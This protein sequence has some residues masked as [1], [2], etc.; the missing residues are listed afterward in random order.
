MSLCSCYYVPTM[1]LWCD[2]HTGDI[3]HPTWGIFWFAWPFRYVVMPQVWTRLYSPGSFFA[4]WAATHSLQLQAWN[5]YVPWALNVIHQFFFTEWTQ[6]IWFFFRWYSGFALKT[7]VNTLGRKAQHERNF[8]RVI[9]GMGCEFHKGNRRDM[10]FHFL[11][12]K[13]NFS[14]CSGSGMT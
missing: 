4:L 8:S 1:L 9:T 7:G 14:Y 2:V 12:K 3:K 11:L 5:Y 10:G 13:I 6:K